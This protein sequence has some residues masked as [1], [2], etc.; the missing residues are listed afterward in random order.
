MTTATAVAPHDTAETS[1]TPGRPLQLVREQPGQELRSPFLVASLVHDLRTP[2]AVIRTALEL[3]S[4]TGDQPRGIASQRLLELA[5]SSAERIARMADEVERPA[6]PGEQ[7]PFASIVRAAVREVE[8][9][10]ARR[11][12][13]D[14]TPGLPAVVDADAHLRIVVN[15]VTNA[16]K[17]S[18]TGS[19]V[20][21]VAGVEDG[22]LTVRVVDEGRG[23]PAADLERVLQPDVRLAGDEVPG[24]G[25][26][27]AIVRELVERVGGTLTLDSEPGVGTT[28]GYDVPARAV[29]A[30]VG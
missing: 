25:L 30:L 9:T 4:E 14:V 18:P 29:G 26:G 3:L 2:L 15:L 1:A 10:T 8:V 16:V 27:L 28:V 19:P 5:T 17:F 23:I 12:R 11:I 6:D 7:V 20:R 13:L 22:T 24:R 21:V